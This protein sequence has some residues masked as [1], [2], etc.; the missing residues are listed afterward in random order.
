MQISAICSASAIANASMSGRFPK[1]GK[2]LLCL[3]EDGDSYRQ[4][5]PQGIDGATAGAP[6]AFRRH[7]VAPG[8]MLLGHRP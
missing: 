3:Q 8:T 4:V 2:P 6:P 7:G 5:G 1:W